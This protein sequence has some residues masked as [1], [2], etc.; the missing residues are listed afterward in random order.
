LQLIV[1]EYGP[2]II[3]L[4]SKCNIIA[5]A[6]SCLPKLN[7]SHDESTVLKEIFAFDK[8][9]HAFP[10]TFD[11]ISKAQLANNKIQKCIT[12]NDP[13]YGTRIIQ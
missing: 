12:N 8:Q 3:Y 2:N 13:D 9:L 1:E 6:P 11:V 10:I 5:N 7:E 4:P